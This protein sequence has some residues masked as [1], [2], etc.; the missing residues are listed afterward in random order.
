MNGAGGGGGLIYDPTFHIDSGSYDVTIGAG[1]SGGCNG[2][3]NGSTGENSV[4]SSLTALGGGG[5]GSK[6]GGSGGG[7]ARI[8]T[9]GGLGT[10]GQGH[11]GGDSISND[12]TCGGGGGAGANGGNAS[13]SFSGNGGDGLQY[14]ISGTSTY[15]SGGGGGGV[16][17]G[18]GDIGT[19]G[20][21]GGGNGGKTSNGIAGVANTGGGGGSGGYNGSYHGG[22]N[23]GS[24]IAIIKFS[25]ATLGP[26]IGTESEIRVQ[27]KSS[28]KVIAPSGSSLNKSITHTF[29]SPKNLSDSTRIKFAIR[30]SRTG[31]NI[32]IGLH[33]SGGSVSEITPNITSIDTFQWITWDVSQISTINKDSI[34]QIIITITNA[35]ETNIFYIDDIYSD[36]GFL[37]E[38]IQSNLMATINWTNDATSTPVIGEYLI[39]IENALNNQRIASLDVNFTSNVDWSGV[40]ADSEG[41]KAFF[42]SS[43]SLSTLTNGQS[44][45]YTL[46]IQ[47]GEGD[48]V[49]VCPDATSLETVELSCP[50]GFYLTNGL[51]L[52]GATAAINTEGG[53]AYWEISGLTGTGGMS[54]VTGL[55]DILSRLKVSVGSNHTITFGTN[56]GL[57]A[58]STDTMIIAFDPT[59][60]QFDLSNLEI[61]DIELTDNVGSIRTLSTTPAE[62]TWGIDIDKTNDTIIFSVP[63]SGIG[64]YTAANMIIIKIGTNTSGGVNQIVNPNIA[65]S[66]QE[67]I[68]INNTEGEEDTLVI[69]IVDSD[70]IT[71]TGA[72]TGY[73][74]F[75]ID[76]GTGEIPGTDNAI[77]CDSVGLTACLNHS[78]GSMASIYTVDLGELTFLSVNKSNST[79]VNHSDGLSGVINSIY[80]DLTSNSENGVIVTAKSSNGWLQGPGSSKIMPVTD[81]NSI[82]INSGLYGFNLPVAS[83]QAYGT[84]IKNA[85]CDTDTTYCGVSSTPKTVFTTNN[86]QVESARIRLDI[87]A[88]AAYTNTPGNYTDTLTFIATASF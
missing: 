26:L 81:G 52:N 72:V 2:E 18:S 29:P 70:S 34:D 65:G 59:N 44:G 47:K 31:S 41:N 24:G 32:K 9:T 21:G 38:N 79:S 49:W 57:I 73:L 1:G 46:Y 51:T 85:S 13:S 48:K 84:I 82:D 67:I 8:G 60:K 27:G 19:G 17:N 14:S 5:G 58:G 40:S 55:N 45:S 63:T 15:Y 20:L 66:V 12:N 83:S 76:T 28:L 74:T 62:N 39:G 75:D 25:S 22:G 23:G 71:V 61:S 69:P 56:Y 77:S 3:C 36:V 30:A 37:V 6:S 87:A 16:R 80:F 35:D 54:V 4:F 53:I 86:A 11:N 10:S 43:A 33:D 7:A 42:H 78:G 64:G 50:G 88:A 68:T